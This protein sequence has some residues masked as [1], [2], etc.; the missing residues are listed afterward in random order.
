MDEKNVSKECGATIVMFA[1][2]L[3]TLVLFIS[4]GVNAF[5]LASSKSQYHHT[6]E[7]SALGAMQAYL[8]AQ[9]ASGTAQQCIN[10]AITRAESIL[11]NSVDTW[12][13]SSLLTNA[14]VPQNQIGTPSSPKENG[15]ITPGNW[16]FEDPGC[17]AATAATLG[18]PC[19]CTITGTFAGNCFKEITDPNAYAS[20]LKIDLKLSSASLMKTIIND[21]EVQFQSSAIA[22]QI[23]RRGAFLIDISPSTVEDTHDSTTQ[24]SFYPDPKQS[25]ECYNGAGWYGKKL[26][27]SGGAHYYRDLATT[28]DNGFYK[29][30]RAFWPPIASNGDFTGINPDE[31]YKNDYRCMNG[32]QTFSP[33]DD[34]N[35]PDYIVDSRI[36]PQPLDSI[37]DGVHEAMERFELRA[38]SGDMI[39]IIGFDNEL[40]RSRASY[41]CKNATCEAMGTEWDYSMFHPDPLAST[42]YQRF[43][44]ATDT[45]IPI[46]SRLDT[47]AANGIDVWLFPRSV[48]NDKISEG[49]VYQHSGSIETYLG[50]DSTFAPR[51]LTDLPLALKTAASMFKASQQSENFVVLFSD[52][53]TN[54]I[55]RTKAK[56]LVTKN[57]PWGAAHPDWFWHIYSTCGATDAH[58]NA[59]LAEVTNIINND[60]VKNNIALHMVLLGDKVQPHSLVRKMSGQCMTDDAARAAGLPFIDVPTTGTGSKY[61]DPVFYGPNKIW[62]EVKKTNG[63]WLPIRSACASGIDKSSDFDAICAGSLVADGALVPPGSFGGVFSGKVDAQS[64]LLCD[65]QGRTTKEQVADAITEIMSRNPY[66]LVK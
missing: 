46:E 57:M 47:D 45:S 61:T 3:V 12:L 43:L 37:L 13:G 26:K 39:G 50:G 33:N 9:K 64:R 38:V 36:S 65:V 25:C 44:R 8:D 31:H 62:N 10:A 54:C 6:A 41:E 20:A 1:L 49:K 27:C 22:S 30:D 59:S 60:Y 42:Q 16:Y 15:T 40:M 21:T 56:L 58:F 23:P 53:L 19:P 51:P 35:V 52:G 66:V 14:L 28:W 7:Q 5:I 4:L 18:I 29:G 32:E 24:F 34:R 48:A 17:S 55:E 11:G 2:L 63:L